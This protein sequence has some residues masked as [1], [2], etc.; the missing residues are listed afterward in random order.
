[1][2][3]ED[4]SVI[5]DYVGQQKNNPAPYKEV[6]GH[7]TY[8]S[9]PDFGQLRKGIRLLKISDFGAAAL[10]NV[11]SLHYHDIQ[12]EQFCAPEVLLKAGW[13]YSAD[14]WNLGMV[15]RIL[16][17]KTDRTMPLIFIIT[18]KLWELLE[19]TSLLDGLGPGS[20]KYSREAHFAQ[21][22]GLLGPPPQ[23]LLDRANK[24]VHSD[25]YTAPGMH[26][27]ASARDIFT[28]CLTIRPFSR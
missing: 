22:I 16:D 13:S 3:F 7:P 4:K 1:M 5:D 23:E 17:V 9:R 26:D 8:Q 24:A 21:M 15:V 19:D 18:S 6:D 14:I 28:S 25:L 20:N 10:G 27:S 11:S 12:P 2:G